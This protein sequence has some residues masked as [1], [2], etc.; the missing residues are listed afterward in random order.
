MDHG[1][2]GGKVAL[3][4]GAASG[5]GKAAVDLFRS[6]GA[7]VVGSDVTPRADILADAGSE[8]DVERL[9][10][11]TVARHGGL[12]IVFANAGISGGFASISE[13]SA[14]DWA[15]ILRINLIG[16]SRSNMPR[17]ISP[18]AAAARSSAR[19]ALQACARAPAER[20]MRR[21]RPESSTW[22][23]PP[24]SSSRAPASASTPSAPA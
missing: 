17:R 11:E 21:R 8:E 5:I 14:S 4:T 23:R 13:Q 15:E 3:V 7:T 22:S 24:P 16:P 12:D 6:E 9:V 20:P 19:R 1:R 10:G 2:L 18:A